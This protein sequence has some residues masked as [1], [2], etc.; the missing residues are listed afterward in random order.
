VLS[1]AGQAGIAALTGVNASFT[2]GA[3]GAARE[4]TFDIFA[5]GPNW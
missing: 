2:I 1:N 5:I 4:F 3:Q